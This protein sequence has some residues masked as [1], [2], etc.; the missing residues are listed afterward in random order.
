[1]KRVVAVVVVLFL[2]FYIMTSPDTAAEIV[3]NIWH[4]AV[5]VA[6]GVGNFLNQLAS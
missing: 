1:M 4:L 3:K 2:V 5:K 6:H